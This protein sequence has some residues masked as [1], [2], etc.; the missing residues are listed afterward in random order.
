MEG[1]TGINPSCPRIRQLGKDSAGKARKDGIKGR[2]HN[3]GG[4]NTQQERGRHSDWE[5]VVVSCVEPAQDGKKNKSGKVSVNRNEESRVKV[6][7]LQSLWLPLD[8]CR[9]HG[10]C[11]VVEC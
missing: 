10:L 1:Q 7:V 5:P 9:V 8:Q 2:D 6:A 4:K 11:E 3:E